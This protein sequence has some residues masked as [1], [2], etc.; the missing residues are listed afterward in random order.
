MWG[1]IGHESKQSA[2]VRQR[3]LHHV[4]DAALAALA[5]LGFPGRAAARLDGRLQLLAQV[6]EELGAAR[7][8]R[9]L[10]GGEVHLCMCICVHVVRSVAC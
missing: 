7:V 10:F 6:E 1:G 5:L 4:D 2:P 8:E 3:L 9:L